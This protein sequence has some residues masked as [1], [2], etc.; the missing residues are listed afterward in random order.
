M[1]MILILLKGLELLIVMGFMRIKNAA[2]EKKFITWAKG[3]SEL[4][5][6][7]LKILYSETKKIQKQLADMETETKANSRSL[8]RIV[9]AADEGRMKAKAAKLLL[10]LANSFEAITD[11]KGGGDIFMEAVRKEAIGV[12]KVAG[13]ERE[14]SEFERRR[15]A[16]R[17]VNR[18]P[19]GY[20]SESKHSSSW[21][22]LVRGTGNIE[23]EAL[24]GDVVKLGRSLGINTPYNETLWRVAEEMAEKGE[25]PGKYTVEDLMKKVKK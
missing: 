6:P 15:R 16:N 18:M 13:I 5:K 2:S 1:N 4:D 23:A 14:G 10:N 8:K 11:R 22:S 20:E 19:K 12:L 17:G 25:K 24:N 7:D 3:Q 9:I 21:M